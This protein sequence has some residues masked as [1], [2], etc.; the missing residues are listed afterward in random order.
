MLKPR[1]EKALN[2]QLNY[3]YLSAYLYLSMSAHFE[4]A[5]L[6]G[7][8]NWMYVQFQEEMTHVMKFF[9]YT[10]ER[11]SRVNLVTI[12]GPAVEWA[13]PA[14]AFDDALKHERTVTERINKLVDLAR[15]ERDHATET[16]LQ[17]YVTEQVEEEANAS[18]IL[19]QLKMAQESKG[20]LFMIDK[21]LAARVFVDSTA[22]PTP[23]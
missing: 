4:A 13:S 2:D 15:E 3:E 17:W 12:P 18:A 23:A 22:K 6:K 11:G 20:A 5:N 16:F 1:M 10:L 14:A 9:H 7:V 19:E 21:D 8:A